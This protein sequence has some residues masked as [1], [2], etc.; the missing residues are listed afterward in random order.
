MLSYL[1]ITLTSGSIKTYGEVHGIGARG[2]RARARALFGPLFGPPGSVRG[3][4]ESASNGASTRPGRSFC[5]PLFC[6]KLPARRAKFG[7]AHHSGFRNPVITGF[8]WVA[9]AEENGTQKKR[10]NLPNCCVTG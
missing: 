1:L 4:I 7:C 8:R 3:P 2:C 6:D 9:R 10:E 5:A